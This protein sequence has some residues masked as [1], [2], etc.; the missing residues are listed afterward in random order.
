MRGVVPVE[1][2]ITEGFVDDMEMV[3]LEH[4]DNLR[5]CAID[6]LCPSP[7]D[8]AADLCC[9]EYGDGKQLSN[10]QHNTALA[11]MAAI[12]MVWLAHKEEEVRTQ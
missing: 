6:G 2:E 4:I 7:I 5:Q 11:T 8:I 3:L 9:P 12:A 1:M 10:L